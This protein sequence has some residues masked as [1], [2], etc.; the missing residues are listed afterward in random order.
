MEQTHGK[1][2][3][4][5][6]L[7]DERLKRAPHYCARVRCLSCYHVWTAVFPVGVD[8]TDLEC[9]ECHAT[10]TEETK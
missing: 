10:W 2:G 5:I 3:Q 6:D 4:V 8:V 7:D 1:A 9:P